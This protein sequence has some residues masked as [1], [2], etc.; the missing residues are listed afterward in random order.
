M[1]NI[2]NYA[3]WE[4]MARRK[5]QFHNSEDWNKINLWGLFYRGEISKLIDKGL[6]I[7]CGHYARRALM[8]VVPSKEAW[9]KHIKPIV[10]EKGGRT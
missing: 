1:G 6:L 8:W 10:L 9:E 5:V 2:A 3:V 4:E 7:P